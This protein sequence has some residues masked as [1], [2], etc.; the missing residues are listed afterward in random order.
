[1]H[2]S[3]P[4]ILCNFFFFCGSCKKF[5][6]WKRLKQLLKLFSCC[7]YR[8]RFIRAGGKKNK[9]LYLWPWQWHKN[10]FKPCSICLQSQ[11][12][13]IITCFHGPARIWLALKKKKKKITQ[14]AFFPPVFL[15][16]M[17]ALLYYLAYISDTGYNNKLEIWG[18]GRKRTLISSNKSLYLS[19]PDSPR[20]VCSAWTYW[21]CVW[22]MARWG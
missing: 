11:C 13:V 17:C 10:R 3:Q 9:N 2:T 15:L 19:E 22:F 20:R 16:C 18:A 7:L 21:P 1:M 5:D 6:S 12:N 4:L 14:G 8:N